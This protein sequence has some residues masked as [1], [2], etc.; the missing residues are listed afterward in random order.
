MKDGKYWMTKLGN[1]LAVVAEHIAVHRYEGAPDVDDRI[2]DAMLSVVVAADKFKPRPGQDTVGYFLNY[3]LRRVAGDVRRGA[4]IAKRW[5]DEAAVYTD[6]APDWLDGN[7]SRD[8][9]ET[10]GVALHER[11]DGPETIGENLWKSKSGIVYETTEVVERLVNEFPDVAAKKMGVPNDDKLGVNILRVLNDAAEMTTAEPAWLQEPAPPSSALDLDYT[12][13]EERTRM[14][15]G[16]PSGTHYVLKPVE[17]DHR[18][19]SVV[20][21]RVK[22]GHPLELPDNGNIVGALRDWLSEVSTVGTLTSSEL[23]EAVNEASKNGAIWFPDEEAFD[24]TRPE[25]PGAVK[26]MKND[27]KA[28]PEQVMSYARTKVLKAWS[29][30]AWEQIK[31][32]IDPSV[33]FYLSIEVEQ[34]M[35]E[36]ASLIDRYSL[37]E[38]AEREIVKFITYKVMNM[39]TDDYETVRTEVSRPLEVGFD[40]FAMPEQLDAD[41][42]RQK[43]L[44]WLDKVMAL[45][46]TKEEV[47]A[48]DKPVKVRVWA[49]QAAAIQ[50]IVLTGASPQQAKMAERQAYAA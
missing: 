23:V 16:V 12:V 39:V 27:R 7:D 47:K 6:V 42:L 29:K 26:E 2:A 32:N 14:V 33:T 49:S 11:Q 46:V 41:A 3:V 44:G 20:V 24:E 15:D 9:A 35:R 34:A 40:W 21:R 8:L 19:D 36:L 28:V 37:S 18:L 48:A 38:Q 43:V 31:M 17:N 13:V 30:W 25:S 10:L 4:T 1:T 22:E 45:A 50:A 5:S